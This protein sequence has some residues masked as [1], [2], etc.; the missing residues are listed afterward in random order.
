MGEFRLFLSVLATDWVG[1]MAGV[2][3]LAFGAYERI[4]QHKARIYW[5]VAILCIFFS[6]FLAWR[7]EHRRAVA[8]EE[9]ANA[10]SGA[11]L[12]PNVEQTMTAYDPTVAATMVV[13]EMAIHNVGSTPSI[14][15]NFRVETSSGTTKFIGHLVEFP[16]EY[17]YVDAERSHIYTIHHSELLFEKT[18]KPIQPGDLARG[19][20]IVRFAGIDFRRIGWTNSDWNVSFEDNAGNRIS[21]SLKIPWEGGSETLQYAPGTEYPLKK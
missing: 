10:V 21:Q 20:L 8:A 4:R 7:D 3:S 13:F 11:V 1:L 5:F 19:W 2:V 12:H 16:D 9:K 18:M 6:T 17:T 15:E 14:A